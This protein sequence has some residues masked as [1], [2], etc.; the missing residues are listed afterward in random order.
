MNKKGRYQFLSPKSRHESEQPLTD[1][2]K[3]S[4]NQ[5][6]KNYDRGGKLE[7]LTSQ[8]LN[9]IKA[10]DVICKRKTKINYLQVELLIGDLRSFS[11][12]QMIRN[13]ICA[14]SCRSGGI[15]F[16]NRRSER[17]KTK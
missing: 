8:P 6:I 1:Q 9:I 2:K 5:Y 16:G 17:R 7:N 10:A 15:F 11:F 3:Y 14:S 12:S 4:L 13:W